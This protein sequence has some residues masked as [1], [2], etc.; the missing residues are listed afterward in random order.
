[1]LQVYL[2]RYILMLISELE[3]AFSEIESAIL[4]AEGAVSMQ[5]VTM[6]SFMEG[7]INHKLAVV[8]V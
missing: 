4:E 2:Y 6:L 5:S 8:V 3:G 1:M 7:G